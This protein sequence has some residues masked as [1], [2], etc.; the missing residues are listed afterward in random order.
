MVPSSGLPPLM[1][2]LSI[3][4]VYGDGVWMRVAG[5]VQKRRHDT[6]AREPRGALLRN[7]KR[8]AALLALGMV[9]TGCRSEARPANVLRTNSDAAPLTAPRVVTERNGGSEFLFISDSTGGS[10]RRLTTK[11]SGV[12]SDPAISH[13]GRWVA[14]SYAESEEGK[15]EVWVASVDG[16]TVARVSGGDEDALMPAF[17]KDDRSLL[18]VRS[19]FNGHYSPIARPRK[20]NLDIYAIP[21]GPDGAIAGA[22]ANQLTHQ[23]FFDLRSLSVSDD[24]ERFL[25]STSGYP[26]GDLI[27]EFQI[28][29]TQHPT[30]IFQPRAKGSPDIG[31]SYGDARYV[32][33]NVIFTAASEPQQGGNYDYNVYSMSGVTGGELTA[34]TKHTGMIEELVVQDGKAFFLD[35][36]GWHPVALRDSL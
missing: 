14:F 16:R 20:H 23:Q 17:G 6:V 28:K 8:W 3:R 27:E 15:S 25:V 29:N 26:I 24:G 4:L 2:N 18:Y 32:G 22:V 36:S 30:R 34:L 19:M 12:E 11:N 7:P 33:M 13:D 21:L 31:P 5:L 10:R 1:T 9:A 35:A